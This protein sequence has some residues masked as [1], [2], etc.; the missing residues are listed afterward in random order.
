MQRKF[1]QS[2]HVPGQL[3]A[4]LSIVWTVPSGCQLVHVSAVQSDADQASII[5][6][7]SSDDDEYLTVQSIGASG[8][9]AEF[10]GDDFV[11]SSGDSHDCYY[12][13][14]ADGT[15]MKITVDYDYNAGQGGG[16]ASDITIVLTFVEGGV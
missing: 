8:T 15:V 9:P 12:P 13:A 7:D 10:D 5:I 16:A 11:D 2:F 4:N 14:I 1:V 6:G 3:S